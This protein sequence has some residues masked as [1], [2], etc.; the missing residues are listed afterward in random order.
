MLNSIEPTRFENPIYPI[1]LKNNACFDPYACKMK[2]EGKGVVKVLPDMLTVVIG[3]T[4][5]NAQLTEAQNENAR[6]MNQVVDALLDAGI[7]QE[8]I[9]TQTYSVFPQY[10]YIDGRQVLRGYSV[11]H[12]LLVTIRDPEKAGEIIDTS[13]QNGANEISQLMFS[14]EDPSR[15]YNEALDRALEDAHHK[16]LSLAAKMGVAVSPRPV[17]IVEERYSQA[18]PTG[19]MGIRSSDAMTNIQTGQLEIT[20]TIS[21][22]YTY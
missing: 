8:D 3:T 14:L 12:S 1:P 11:T 16:V 2:V 15:Y 18:S 21:V 13:V 4:V 22:L 5:E 10:D 7:P 20:A 9:Q 17:S 6:I 19:V